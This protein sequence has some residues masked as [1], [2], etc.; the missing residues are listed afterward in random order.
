MIALVRL[1]ERMIHGQVAIKWS[2]TLGVD[3]I[4]VVSDMAAGKPLILKSLLMATPPTAKTAIKGVDDAIALLKDPH[5][6]SHKILVIVSIPE[7][8]LRLVE[9]VPEIKEVNIG[10]YGRVA[11]KHGTE[12]R[13]AYKTNFYAYDDEVETLKK[14]MRKVEKCYYQVVPDDVPE[15]LEKVLK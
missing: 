6:A 7:D 11:S 9:N 5:G 2:R 3:R 15:D 14:V 10:N 13:K 4:V 1:D 12:M 8:L